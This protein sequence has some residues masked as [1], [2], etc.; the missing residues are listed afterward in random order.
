MNCPECGTYNP[1][2]R[3]RCWR[4]G[5]ELP[6]PKPVKKKDPQKS[7]KTAMYLAAAF[8][9]ITTLLQ[10]CG[11]GSHTPGMLEEGEPTGYVVP[12]AFDD[13]LV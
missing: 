2:D 6:Q 13:G 5:H 4:C 8:L 10:F 9:I 12:W 11:M 7:W 1:D 3:K